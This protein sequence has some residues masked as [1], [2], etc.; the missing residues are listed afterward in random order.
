MANAAPIG[1]KRR[2][3]GPR[4]EVAVRVFG[5]GERKGSGSESRWGTRLRDLAM[6][7]PGAAMQRFLG[8]LLCLCALRLPAGSGAA[9]RGLDVASYR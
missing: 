1:W 5:E 2:R 3:G 8:P 7:G 6:R 9:A 4:A